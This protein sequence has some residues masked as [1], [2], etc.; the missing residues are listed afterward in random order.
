MAERSFKGFFDALDKEKKMN[1]CDGCQAKMPLD[2]GNRHQLNGRTFMGCEKEKYKETPMTLNEK[3]RLEVV[4]EQKD[5]AL[6]D[7]EKR[8]E[9]YRESM[10]DMGRQNAV[11]REHNEKLSGRASHWYGVAANHADTITQLRQE[12]ADANRCNVHSQEQVLDLEREIEDLKKNVQLLREISIQRLND[13]VK[14]DK[15]N[16]ELND[17]ISALNKEDVALLDHNKALA[18]EN[19][20]LWGVNAEQREAHTAEMLSIR[21]RLIRLADEI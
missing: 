14:L 10:I 18:E 13:N 5:A 4:I 16:K 3:T 9:V 6:L 8:V 15:A 11:L 7:A 21:N 19:R 17:T 20:K 2:D 12:L 1:Q